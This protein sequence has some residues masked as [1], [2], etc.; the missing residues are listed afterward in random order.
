MIASVENADPTGALIALVVTVIVVVVATMPIWGSVLFGIIGTLT[1]KKHLASIRAREDA[2]R[3]VPVV[4]IPVS[5]S[6]REVAD[7]RMVVG[8]MVICPDS[9]RRFI[10]GIRNLI[11][12]RVATFEGLLDRARRE[13]ILRMKEQAPDADAI[14]NLRMET[15]R[16]GGNDQRKGILAIEV[17]AWGTAIRYAPEQEQADP[18]Q[19]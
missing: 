7:S 17:L 3:H 14:V 2:T 15:S 11:G 18:A 5:D 10:A 9:F 16:I 4:P 13:A 6:T 19:S 12:G 1:E 8:A